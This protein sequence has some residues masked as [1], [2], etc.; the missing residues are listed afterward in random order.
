VGGL[1]KVGEVVVYTF[2]VAGTMVVNAAV[3]IVELAWAVLA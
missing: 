2:G 1:G 3:H